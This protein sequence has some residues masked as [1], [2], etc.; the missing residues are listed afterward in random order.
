MKLRIHQNP[1]LVV[2]MV[3]VM[4]MFMVSMDGTIVNVI[5]PAIGQEFNVAPSATSGI[6]VGYLVSIAVFLPISGWLGDRFGTKKIF[7][8]ALGVFTVASLLCGFATS[9]ENL[10]LFR[11]LQGAGGGLLTPVG[12]AILFRTFTQEERPK[13]SRTLILPIAF[14]P[15]IG[16]IVG[17]FFAEQLSWSWAFYINI[18]F[19]I[20]A[21]LIGL[22]FLKE[23]K[24]PAAGRLDLA[25]FLLSALGLSMLMYALSTGPSKGWDSP[26]IVYTGIIGFILVCLFV[27]L[28]LRVKEPMLNL[29]L[30]SDRLF[31]SLGLISLLSQAALMGMLFV[32][33]L[34]YQNAM[35]ASALES[36]L[37]TFPEALGLMIASR[38]IPWTSK[39]LNGQQ[40][41]CLG[42]LG[43]ALIFTMISF[44]G[45]TANPWFLRALLFGVGVC[46]GHAVIA[47][48]SSIFTNVTSSSMGRATT[49]FN[50]QNRVGSAVGVA[51]LASVLGALGTSE[52]RTD[53]MVQIDLASYQFALLGSAVFLVI[54]LIISLSLK[55]TDFKSLLPN[56]KTREIPKTETFT[57]NK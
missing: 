8:L 33:P 38:M 57:A 28:E 24:E 12:M 7:L 44:V 48:Q 10:T 31:R 23:H 21:W 43:T 45:P 50:V 46:L 5:L 6:N 37:A 54:G 52:K 16:P 22:L 29:R 39:R 42:L 2:C 15:A 13:V 1:K 17:G 3:Y 32:F 40:I 11:A 20:V 56:Q 36:G 9:L 41:I 27:W 25:G 47:V 53:G 34:M 4:A 49:L 14:A 30:L 19:G 26:V 51:I 55:K 18:P 35:N